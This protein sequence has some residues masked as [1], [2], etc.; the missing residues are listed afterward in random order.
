MTRDGKQTLLRTWARDLFGEELATT[1]RTR[2]LRFIEE[3]AE[4]ASAAEAELLAVVDR[5]N[6]TFRQR[7]LAM[8]G[9]WLVLLWASFRFDRAT[10]GYLTGRIRFAVLA[11]GVLGSFLLYP[12]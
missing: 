2:L 7:Y 1:K 6:R 8:A 12:S 3:A 4:L 11:I 9:L 5:L 10:R